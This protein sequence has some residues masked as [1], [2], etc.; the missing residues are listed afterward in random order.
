MKE[1]QVLP[2]AIVKDLQS[3]NT[4]K[5]GVR[6]F[7]AECRVTKISKFFISEREKKL[8]FLCR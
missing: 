2:V 6:I 7:L 5:N 1:S 4:T 3:T 8:F